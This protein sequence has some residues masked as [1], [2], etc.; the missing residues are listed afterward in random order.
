MVGDADDA[1]VV[2]SAAVAAIG[3][4]IF[5]VGDEVD[6]DDVEEEGVPLAMTDC[7]TADRRARADSRAGSTTDVRAVIS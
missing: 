1:A 5:L 3:D 6:D 4:A 7:K 2:V